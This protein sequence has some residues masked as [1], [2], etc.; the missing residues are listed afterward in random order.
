[1]IRFGDVALPHRFWNNVKVDSAGCWLWTGTQHEQGYGLLCVGR[2]KHRAHRMTYETLV[3]VVPDGL[4]LDHLCRV[5]RCVNPEHL[6][7]VTQH[8]NIMRGNG[9][10]A[11]N[12]RKTYCPQ[13]H[14]YSGA[15]LRVTP[16]GWRYCFTC[17]QERD[18]KRA[19]KTP[20]DPE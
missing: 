4:V 11:A 20:R 6:E 9:P 18:A 8:E 3:G 12:A 10:T 13:G 7:A 5:T 19:P 1:M 15:N 17:K 16:D 2:R 14:P